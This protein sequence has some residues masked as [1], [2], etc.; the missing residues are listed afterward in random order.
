VICP[1]LAA[2][3]VSAMRGPVFMRDAAPTLAHLLDL[4]GGTTP[5]GTWELWLPVRPGTV[6]PP[7]TA[8]SVAN[9]A[10]DSETP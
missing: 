8:P 4:F 2:R 5:S 10:T 6:R 3:L 1:L 9:H 7:A